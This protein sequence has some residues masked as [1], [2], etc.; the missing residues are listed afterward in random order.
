MLTGG[1]LA[2][3]PMPPWA[4]LGAS[5]AALRNFALA[6]AQEVRPDGVRVAMVQICGRIEPGGFFDPDASPKPIGSCT[7]GNRRLSGKKSSISPRRS[8][9][10]EAAARQSVFIH[11]A[12]I[13][14]KRRADACRLLIRSRSSCGRRRERPDPSR[15]SNSPRRTRIASV[16]RGGALCQRPWS[17]RRSP[18]RIPWSRAFAQ[19][20][21]I[22]E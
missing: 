18:D 10:R 20:F 12:L 21:D 14:S 9:R 17:R 3:E 7:M 19:L 5:K 22:V 4:A 1:S 11:T 16:A 13:L 15:C 6:L 2:F 8:R